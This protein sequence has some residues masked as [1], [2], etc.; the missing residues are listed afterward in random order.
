MTT[1]SLKDLINSDPENAARTDAEVLAWLNSGSGEFGSRMVN[2]R[3]ILATLGASGGAVLL[4]KLEQAAL[5]N[6]AV[7]WALKF[8][9]EQGIDVGNTQT[10]ATLDALV[11]AAV[12]TDGE[13]NAVKA[14]APE[15]SRWEAAG[16]SRPQIGH[17]RRWRDGV[18]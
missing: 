3:E 17:V 1:T 7:K 8:M 18:I 6:P 16:L 5:V 14:I 10:R 15:L 13:S 9:T 11:N 2:A 12:L 4:E